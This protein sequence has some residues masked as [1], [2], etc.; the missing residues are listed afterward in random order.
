MINCSKQIVLCV[1]L[2]LY[3]VYITEV[4]LPNEYAALVTQQMTTPSLDEAKSTG[5]SSLLTTWSIAVIVVGLACITIV[6][7]VVSLL[8][9][10]TKFKGYGTFYLPSLI[11]NSN[12]QCF[13]RTLDYLEISRGSTKISLK[14]TT[15]QNLKLG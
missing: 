11:C 7:V 4:L 9:C 8:L 2:Q 6:I 10:R 1:F 5:S 3:S 12:T 13:H 14:T 15:N